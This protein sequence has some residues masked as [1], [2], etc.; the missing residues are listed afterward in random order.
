VQRVVV[1]SR[2]SWEAH[3]VGHCAINTRN[4]GLPDCAEL[5]IN[6]VRCAT[7]SPFYASKMHICNEYTHFLRMKVTCRKHIRR[8]AFVGREWRMGIKRSKEPGDLGCQ[9]IFRL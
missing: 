4:M 3:P 2:G 8:V 7:Q 6:T 1:R 9:Q 5:E